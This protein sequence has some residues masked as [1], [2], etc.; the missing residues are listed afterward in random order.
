MDSLEVDYLD[1]I[2]KLLNLE[3][4]FNR[5]KKSDF[6][7]IKSIIE[8]SIDPHSNIVSILKQLH[9]KD[10]FSVEDL[11]KKYSKYLFE[12]NCH[13]Y[14]F[15]FG[16]LA[17][18]FG[19]KTTILD[20]YGIE[21]LRKT[22]N[23]IIRSQPEDRFFVLGLNHNPQCLVSLE[24]DNKEV[25]VS[26]KH[27]KLDGDRLVSSLNPVCHERSI[28]I[29]KLEDGYLLKANSFDHLKFPVWLKSK[30]AEKE[31]KYYKVFERK[32]MSI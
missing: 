30:R 26:P 17:S 16:L 9:S 27:F 32:E 13:Q 29:K 28:Y 1:R 7:L 2:G 24:M 5:V 3:D 22:N 31:V 20:C 21:D 11:F 15:A 25:L 8:S 23:K 12:G 14:S 19:L 10:S 6:S 4:I 18:V